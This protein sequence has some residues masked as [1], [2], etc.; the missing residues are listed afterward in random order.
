MNRQSYI[1]RP[2]DNHFLLVNTK[3]PLNTIL[4]EAGHSKFEWI[5]NQDA[6]RVINI[7]ETGRWT[8]SKDYNNDYGTSTLT[9]SQNPCAPVEVTLTKLDDLNIDDS[10]FTSLPTG[11][12]FDQFCST[13]GG[14]LP[15]TNIMAVGD[16]GVGKTSLLCNLLSNIQSFDSTKKVLF[17]SAEMNRMD[18]ARYLKRFP[19]WGQLP[20]LFLND[21]EDTAKIAL[22]QTLSQGWDI[23]LTDS[24]TEVGDTIKASNN[25]TQSKAEKWFLSLMDKHN[26]GENDSKKY[27]TFITIL[28][29]NKSGQFA[30]SNK[31]KHITSAM[32]H[33]RW[34]GNE[35]SGR[36]YIEFSKNRCGQVGKKLYF[37]LDGGITFDESRYTRDLFNDEVLAEERKALNNES[38]AF[39]RLF[40]FDKDA[41]P[42]ELKTQVVEL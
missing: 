41:I 31:L 10:L 21:Y 2:Q 30:G 17:I 1:I 26:K 13:E 29:V 27:T 35:N 34:D 3:D 4:I 19:H 9:Q 15:G 11:T 22:E 24:Y 25:M 36:R 14:F 28:Q 6:N 32:L 7:T 39:D 16:P 37:S 40:G 18:M 20:I 12:V 42:E 38:N 33:L 23:V 8:S 5:S